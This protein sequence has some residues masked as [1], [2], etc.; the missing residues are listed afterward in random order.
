MCR[1]ILT[2][3]PNGLNIT[4]GDSGTKLLVTAGSGARNLVLPDG[5]RIVDLDASFSSRPMTNLASVSGPLDPAYV[6]YTS[7]STGRPKAVAVPHVA[8][9]NFLWSMRQRRA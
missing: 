6:I 8:V 2:F 9:V 3:R 4:L 1:S 5:I 7:G